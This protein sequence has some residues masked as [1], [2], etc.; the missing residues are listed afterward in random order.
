MKKSL[1]PRHLKRIGIM[2]QLFSDSFK[3]KRQN[4]QNPDIIGI[5]KNQEGIDNLIEGSAPQFPI[6]KIARV[7]VAILRLAVYELMIAK[8]EPFK[9]IID[10]AVELAKE[11][12]SA[13]SSSFINGV[14]GTIY[15]KLSNE[16]R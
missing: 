14:L 6:K 13:S 11:F 15:N 12:G 9:V 8:K 2:Q 16:S 4:V 5:Y 1:D 10:E 3:N 7:D